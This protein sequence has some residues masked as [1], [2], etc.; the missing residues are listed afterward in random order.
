MTIVSRGSLQQILVEEQSLVVLRMLA[1]SR[2]LVVKC[3]FLP[4]PLTPGPFYGPTETL[5]QWEFF[6]K[7]NVP[8]PSIKTADINATEMFPL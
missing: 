7:K 6:L 1:P 4:Q 3:G 8:Q 2:P 5:F